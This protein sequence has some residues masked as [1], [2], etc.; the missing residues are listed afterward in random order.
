MLNIPRKARG[1]IGPLCGSDLAGGSD[2][3]DRWFRLDS[4]VSKTLFLTFEDF[5]ECSPF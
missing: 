4:V 1:R 2:L 3:G 5:T